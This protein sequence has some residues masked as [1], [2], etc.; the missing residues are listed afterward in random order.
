MNEDVSLTLSQGALFLYAHRSRVSQPLNLSTV[1]NCLSDQ[2]RCN[3][4][5]EPVPSVS[6]TGNTRLAGY[7]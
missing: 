1:N 4:G 2:T 7:C 3:E 5:E 6:T